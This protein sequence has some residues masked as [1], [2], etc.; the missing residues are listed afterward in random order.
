[1]GTLSTLLRH[2][3]LA[4]AVD[5][6][7]ASAALTAVAR[8]DSQ[9]FPRH[10]HDEVLTVLRLLKLRREAKTREGLPAA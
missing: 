6:D 7:L 10:L 8:T 2:P 5:G 1:M 9:P 3:T 4:P